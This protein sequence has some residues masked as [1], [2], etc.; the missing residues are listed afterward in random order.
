M[1]A[2]LARNWWLL[3]LRGI[4]ALA[5][6]I[7]TFLVPGVAIAALVLAFGLWAAVDGAFALI[8]AFGPNAHHRVIL[9]LEGIVGLGAAFVTFRY[10][11]LTGITLLYLIA[12]WAIVTGVLE[13]VAA[14]QLRKQI[15]DEWWLIVAGALSILFGVL[16]LIN[17]GSGALAV[18]WIIGFYA[19][20]FG[21]SMVLLSFRLRKINT[22]HAT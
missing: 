5:F 20:L 6:G 13:I 3:L 15:D 4:A 18:L 22:A 10:P 16:L 19:I 21:V 14:V 1:L 12:W 8:A 17:P 9:I 7:A 2:G 11:L